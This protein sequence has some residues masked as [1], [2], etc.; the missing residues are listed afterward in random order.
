MR[1]QLFNNLPAKGP[2]NTS[3]AALNIMPP[4]RFL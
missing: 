3:K 1:Y 2:L 4:T